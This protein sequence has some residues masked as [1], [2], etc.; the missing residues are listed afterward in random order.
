MRTPE[1]DEY[2]VRFVPF[3][4]IGRA[5]D[6]IFLFIK[7]ALNAHKEYHAGTT[8]FKK[9]K[10][11]LDLMDGEDYYHVPGV[12]DYILTKDEFEAVTGKRP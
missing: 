7:G 3:R 11:I 5:G 9:I 6:T 4:A 10:P 12:L 8:T 1:D 2:M